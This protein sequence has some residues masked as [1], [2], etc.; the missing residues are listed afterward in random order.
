M[1]GIV[2]KDDSAPLYDHTKAISM[3]I[4]R[5]KWVSQTWGSCADV[6][7]VSIELV[8]ILFFAGFVVVRTMTLYLHQD[9]LQ[10]VVS[11]PGKSMT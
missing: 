9:P 3:F 2:Q 6:K 8:M 7:C 1:R 10:E 11:I 5:E 4:V